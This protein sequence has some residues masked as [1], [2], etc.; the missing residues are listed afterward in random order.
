MRPRLPSHV[1]R[2][3]AADGCRTPQVRH[4]VIT[5]INLELLQMDAGR[6][7]CVTW[8]S[9][10]LAS[11]AAEGG[12]PARMRYLVITHTARNHATPSPLALALALAASPSPSPNPDSNSSPNPSPGPTSCQVPA[13][14]HTP[15]ALRCRGF[16]RCRGRGRGR[17]APGVRRSGRGVS[18]IQRGPVCGAKGLREVQ[19]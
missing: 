3:T 5:H 14:P 1:P 12:R 8:L 7:R 13:L 17:G 6:G 4:L 18:S 11:A 16:C 19:S 9:P 2:T 10:I 15:R